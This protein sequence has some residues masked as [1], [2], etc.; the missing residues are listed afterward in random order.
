MVFVCL[1]YREDTV[2]KTNVGGLKDMKKERKVVWI[3]PSSDV[4]HCPVRLV[5]K[6]LSLCP[7]VKKK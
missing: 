6:Y 4:T 7:E 1:V 5:D 3:H 2:T